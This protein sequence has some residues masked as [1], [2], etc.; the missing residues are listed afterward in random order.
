MNPSQCLGGCDQKKK[1]KTQWENDS[2]N[3]VKMEYRKRDWIDTR[4]G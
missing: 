1:K 4:K 2:M 3:E